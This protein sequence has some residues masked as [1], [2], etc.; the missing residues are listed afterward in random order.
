MKKFIKVALV[1]MGILVLFLLIAKIT[2]KL[3][4]PND[5]PNKINLLKVVFYVEMTYLLLSFRTVKPKQLAAFLFFEKPITEVGPGLKLVPLGICSLA[6]ETRLTQQ[7]QFPGDPEDVDKTGENI[8]ASG[9]VAPIRVTHAGSTNPDPEPLER[10][11]TTEVSALCR[12]RINA[13]LTFLKTI[14]SIQEMHRQ[15]RDTVEVELKIQLAQRT[16]SKTLSEW[17]AINKILKTKVQDLTSGWGV[18]IEDVQMV[19]LDLGKTVNEALRDLPA[20]ELRSKKLAVDGDADS[21]YT[22]KTKQ[23]EADGLEYVLL[24]EAKGAEKKAAIARDENGRFVLYLETMDQA[25]K[26]AK[27]TIIAGGGDIFSSVASISTVLEKIKEGGQ[28]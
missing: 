4:A 18:L 24:A 10:R 7:F 14:G 27:H 26:N 20:A 19:D 16:V 13:Y 6:I 22:R 2:M 25:F 21:N 28:K 17:D 23:A 11:M 8:I 1:L 15:I 5:W 3:S 9:K 12:F